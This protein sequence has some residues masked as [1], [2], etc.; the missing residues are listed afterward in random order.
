MG[1]NQLCAVMSPGGQQGPS[2]VPALARIE[3][4][5]K[6]PDDRDDHCQLAI[7]RSGGAGGAEAGVESSRGD[8]GGLRR[9]ADTVPWLRR[10]IGGF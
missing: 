9:R 2:L 5:G 1:L 3:M 8:E 10:G 6:Q 4:H 7:L